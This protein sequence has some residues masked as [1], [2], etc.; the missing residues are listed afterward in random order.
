MEPFEVVVHGTGSRDNVLVPPHSAGVTAAFPDASP[1]ASDASERYTVTPGTPAPAAL[2]ALNTTVTLWAATR[3]P[4]GAIGDGEN[5]YFA[6]VLARGPLSAGAPDDRT[7][8]EAKAAGTRNVAE[9]S[10]PT[11]TRAS[12]RSAICF[13][14]FNIQTTLPI[15]HARGL[16]HHDA[17]NP[18]PRPV[19][20][21]KTPALQD[22]P[23]K[24][25][26]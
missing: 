1:P 23:W 15:T 9:K 22:D 8:P 6:T 16:H 20:E 24:P 3:L 14:P 21:T 12:P 2:S 7:P 13:Q 10:A 5:T 26:V 19:H 4:A 11:A 25:T 18:A 17:E